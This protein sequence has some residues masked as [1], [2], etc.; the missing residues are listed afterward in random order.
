MSA[1]PPTGEPL[2]GNFVRLDPMRPA[3]AEGLHAVYTDPVVYSQGFIMRP[4][5]A[6]L[7]AT[8]ADT[9]ATIAERPGRTAYT[10]RLT[11]EGG[12]GEAG[13][14][15]GTSSL[16]DVDLVNERIHLG[17]TM[18]HSGVWGT[19]VNPECKLLLIGHAFDCGFGRVKIQT[20]A[21]NARSQAAIAKLGATR[22]GVLR[23]HTRRADGTFRDTVVFSVLREEWPA[24][25][26]GLEQRLGMPRG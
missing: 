3:D 14:I 23:R 19:K 9:E 18:Y 15:V 5:P 22:E 26:A 12:L 8:R 11:G 4:P 6:D 16:G 10:V 20:D 21:V 25:R 13:T 2:V 17:W 1:N 24:V 7:T